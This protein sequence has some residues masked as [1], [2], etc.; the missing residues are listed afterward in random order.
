MF[1]FRLKRV[2]NFEKT[3]I[4]FITHQILLKM[5]L[6]N[7][8]KLFASLF[9]I[10]I[11]QHSLILNKFWMN[12][13]EMIFN[14]INDECYFTS[15]HCDHVETFFLLSRSFVSQKL[16]NSNKQFNK[17]LYLSLF[18]RFLTSFSFVSV[19]KYQILQRRT[20]STSFRLKSSRSIIENS[21][22]EKQSSEKSLNSDSKYV[23]EKI[24]KDYFSDKLI[25]KKQRA[26]I[27]REA[28]KSNLINV[29]IRKSNIIKKFIRR[30]SR[31]FRATVFENDD[32]EKN[33]DFDAFLNVA[34]IDATAFQFLTDS[35][36]KKK[37]S[38][39]S[40]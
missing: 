15:N 26:K 2:F 9:I 7:H 14:M 38:R 8:S 37:K 39:S 25:K 5:I 30:S 40:R 24:D 12:K 20:V 27:I 21:T 4:K 16:F 17:T 36:E 23:I 13:H 33:F 28:Q 32:D 11:E 6:Q 31:R 29:S 34:F 22:K 1:L 35:R 3:E 19:Q 10:K 18:D